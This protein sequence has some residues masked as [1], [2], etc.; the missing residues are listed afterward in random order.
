[1][2]IYDYTIKQGNGQEISMDTYTGE[3]LLLVNTATKC[4]LA[5]QFKELETLHQR[6]QAEG[7][8]VLGFPCSQFANQEA[9][10][11]EAIQST[12]QL[13]FG[14]TFPIMAKIDV[15]GKN[16]EPLFQ[17]LKQETKSL[18]GKELKWNFT[19]FLVDRQGKVIKRY[20]P[21]VSPLKI[22]QDIKRLLAQ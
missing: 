10:D 18:L 21:T 11:N 9:A 5:P 8:R 12:C 15:N 13:N 2:K 16:A 20:A 4:G 6:Y 17:F 7:L 1:M 14:V 3:V 22:E 19:K